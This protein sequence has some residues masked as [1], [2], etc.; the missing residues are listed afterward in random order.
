[1]LEQINI[2][3]FEKRPYAAMILGAVYVF[4]A[5]FTSKIFFPTMISVSMLFLVTLLLVPTVLKLIYVEEKRE[6]RDG[7]RNFLRD[8]RD[9]F[10]IYLFLFIGIF[11]ALIFLGLFY[12]TQNFD[13]QLKFLQNQE[14]LSSE[15]VKTKTE[16]GIV[17]SPSNFFALLQ[18]NL[19]V[20]IVSFLLSFF[21][22]AGAMF[23]I[24][25]NASVFSTFIMFIM[26]EL[27]T[28]INKTSILLI[29]MVHTVPELFGFLLAA[30]AGGVLSK[31]LLQEKF[32][33]DRFRNVVKDSFLIFFLAVVIIIIAALLETYVTPSLFNAIL[34]K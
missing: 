16:M 6:S 28:V 31:A 33:S 9:V 14:G 26:K 34:V 17:I 32:L 18:S 1:M 2:K 27:P 24:V 10:E 5:F 7:S 30:V 8:H 23:L 11:V 3:F 21:Y 4:V 15:L 20:I 29:F 12:G 19:T 22:G 13:Y 25:L